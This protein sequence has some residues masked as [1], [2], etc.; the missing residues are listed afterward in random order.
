MA[1][2]NNRNV[3]VTP[4]GL[5]TLA[6]N[7]LSKV[8]G[9][10]LWHLVMTLQ[11]SGDVVSQSQLATNLAIALR[12]VNRAMKLLCTQGFLMRGAKVGLSYHYKL[13]PAYLRII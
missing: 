5:Q 1:G 3:V 2:E 6:R 4:S 9:M 11:V 10:I 13:N 8:E 7:P 12:Q